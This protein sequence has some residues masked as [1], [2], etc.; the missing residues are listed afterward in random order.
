VNKARKSIPVFAVSFVQAGS[1]NLMAGP[2]S[3]PVESN[4]PVIDA[5]RPQGK[6]F[7]GRPSYRGI[8]TLAFSLGAS[9]S[10]SRRDE[11]ARYT[12]V[13]LRGVVVY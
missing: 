13:H 3:E 8:T 5:C 4:N 10:T 7:L 6:L 9:D 2:R 11:I 1:P 12:E